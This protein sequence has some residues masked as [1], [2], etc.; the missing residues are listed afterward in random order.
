[1]HSLSNTSLKLQLSLYAGRN[2]AVLV[3]G[4]KKYLYKIAQLTSGKNCGCF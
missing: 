2:A 1:M 3:L 4:K